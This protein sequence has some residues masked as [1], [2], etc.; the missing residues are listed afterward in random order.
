MLGIALDDLDQVRDQVSAALVG[1]FDVAPSGGDRFLIGLHSVV[2][3][4]GQQ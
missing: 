3:A 4:A 1:R 2:A